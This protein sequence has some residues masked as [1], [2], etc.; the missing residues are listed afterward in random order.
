[1]QKKGH[2]KKLPKPD[3]LTLYMILILTD[4]FNLINNQEYFLLIKSS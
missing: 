3:L 1:M 4:F 2:L